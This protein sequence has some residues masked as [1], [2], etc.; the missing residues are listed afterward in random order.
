[1]AYNFKQHMGKHNYSEENRIQNYDNEHLRQKM[2]PKRAAKGN[3]HQS[4]GKIRKGLALVVNDITTIVGEQ[5]I[6]YI[7]PGEFI[8]FL[9]EKLSN[10]AVRI[11]FSNGHHY[12]GKKETSYHQSV[13]VSSKN[14]KP[15]I[16]Y[17]KKGN[18]IV[19]IP[20]KNQGDENVISTENML[21][22]ITADDT[23]IIP[24]KYSGGDFGHQSNKK[25]S[26][27]EFRWLISRENL[28]KLQTKGSLPNG[29]F[30]GYLY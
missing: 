4:K 15:T 16:A 21:E 27:K 7:V 18:G 12:G 13:R 14:V 6:D 2:E 30:Y 17:Q 5:N 26:E 28:K 24:P 22:D 29:V 3:A 23:G 25:V 8:D 1:M 10:A 19:N 11:N 9:V 20:S